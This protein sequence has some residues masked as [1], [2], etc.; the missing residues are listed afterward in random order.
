MCYKKSI[1]GLSRSRIEKLPNKLG[2]GKIVCVTATTLVNCQ[3]WSVNLL[4]GK[5][6]SSD[7]AFHF[8]PRLLQHFIVRNSRVKG[9][10]GHEEYLLITPFNIKHGEDFK[11]EIFTA[12]DQFFVTYNKKHVCNFRFRLPLHSISHIEVCGMVDVHEIEIETFDKFPVNEDDIFVIE[13]MSKPLK[14]EQKMETPIRSI[15]PEG[16]Q[17][18]WQLEIYGTPKLLPQTF[19]IDLRSC[20]Y[21][22]PPNTIALQLNTIFGNNMLVRNA[23]IDNKWGMEERIGGSKFLPA[24]P[25]SLWIRR[26]TKK[27]S[28]WV[29]EKLQVEFA[30]RCDPELVKAVHILGDVDING[31]Y[32]NKNPE[33]YF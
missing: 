21:V 29:N 22:W 32:V 5:D 20:V 12:D 6:N 10:W 25:F 24:T 2:R 15:L 8:N 16:L 17:E 1:S 26:S 11:L 27:Y 3:R 9:Q 19:S 23:F 28:I 7:I 18:D 31:I 30:F 4:C 33:R 13:E 14:E